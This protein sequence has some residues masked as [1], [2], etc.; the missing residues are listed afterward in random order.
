[1]ALAKRVIDQWAD[2]RWRLNNLYWITDKKGH[3]VPFRLNGAQEKLLDELWYLNIVLKARQLG[4]TTLIDLFILDACVFNSNVRGGI[5][6]H[7]LEDSKTIFKDKVKYPY[8]HLPERI[9]AIQRAPQDSAT[10]LSFANNSSIRVGTSLRSGTYQYMHISEHGKICAKYPEKAKEIKTGSLNT[11]EAGQMAFIEST[12]EGQGGDFFDMCERAQTKQRLGTPLTTM[13]FK[14]HFFPWWQDPDYVLDDEVLIAQ[15]RQDYFAKLQAEHGIALT[16][17]QQAWYVKKAEQQGDDMKREYP[18]T[19]E[20]AFAAAVE[21]AYYGK[22]MNKAEA[23][24]RI[25]N[26]AHEPAALVETWWDLGI[27]RNRGRM[28]DS[29]AIWF[30]QRVGQEVHLIDYLAGS[31][32]ALAF[33]VN[34]LHQKRDDLEYNYG[35]H[36][37]PHD[38]KATELGTG[39]TR[40][41]VLE[42]LGVTVTLAPDLLVADGIEAVRNMLGRCWFDQERCERGVAALKNYR[43]EWDEDRGVFRSTPLHDWCADPADAFRMGAVTEVPGFGTGQKINYPNLGVV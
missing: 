2:P 32:E 21:G 16:A 20:E 17:A 14:F 33:Y 40:E 30:A 1:M 9:R 35:S 25:G 27:A 31:G 43:K 10:A 37:L 15:D 6:A 38:V 3:E 23:E 13:D 29:M 41:E 36:V 39:K 19:P 8:D 24:G 42:N 28:G 11:V 18:S 4:F 34:I 5:I 12:A 26:V 7:T 22:Q